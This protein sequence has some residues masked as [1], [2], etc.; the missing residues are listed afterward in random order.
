MKRNGTSD[1]TYDDE[2]V[3]N[4]APRMVLW[5]ATRRFMLAWQSIS[6]EYCWYG[7]RLAA[8]CSITIFPVS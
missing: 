3:M 8:G 5:W 6:A 7:I 4:G 1:R 2:T